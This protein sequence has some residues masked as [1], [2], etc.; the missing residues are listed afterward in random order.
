MDDARRIIE[1]LGLQPHPEGGW[2][3]E[4]W[5]AEAAPGERAGATAIHFL[6]DHGQKSHWH[7]VDAAEM[8]LWHAG[9]PLR[10]RT[11]P[12]D[13]GPVTEI[14]LGGDV[15]AGQEPQHIIAPHHWQAA[16]AHEG[17]A[18]VSC[19]VSPGFDFAGFVLAPP[20]W[21]PAA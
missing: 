7:T 10:L 6:L 3:R 1:K 13:D 17:W 19:I 5:R 15:L 8:W 4:T 9:H 14:L 20:D 21:E 12:G 2:Y 18:L 16:E 11:A